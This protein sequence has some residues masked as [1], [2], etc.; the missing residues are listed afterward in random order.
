MDIRQ[1]TRE[2]RIAREIADELYRAIG[3]TMPETLGD[4][5]DLVREIFGKV[6]DR[7]GIANEATAARILAKVPKL[8]ADLNLQ[9][10]DL[11]R[12][13]DAAVKHA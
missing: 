4:H 10:A 13:L 8:L 6:F 1:M 12:R 11:H 9:F 7:H 2:R 5:G 3:P